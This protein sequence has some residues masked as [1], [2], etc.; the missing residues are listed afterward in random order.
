MIEFGRVGDG[1]YVFGW[2]L[3]PAIALATV[4][5]TSLLEIWVGSRL[6]PR[7][8]RTTI[9]VCGFGLPVLLVAGA[10]IVG[11]FWDE[12]VPTNP[13]PEFLM[14]PEALTTS[15]LLVAVMILPVSLLTSFGWYLRRQRRR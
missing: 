2:G 9:M 5:F 6:S 12:N 7:F 14:L 3:I 4:A 15:L 10:F 8:P 13:T 11:A 1:W